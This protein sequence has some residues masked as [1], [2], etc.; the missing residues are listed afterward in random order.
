MFHQLVVHLLDE[1]RTTVA[2]LGQMLDGILD[3]VEAVNLVLHAHIEGRGD[4]AFLLVAVHAQVTVD[5]VVG[6]LMNEGGIAVERKDD[7]LVLCEQGVVVGVGETCLLYT[8]DA[9]DE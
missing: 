2:Q 7:G 9:A 4:G 8:S 3:Q 6:Q 5:T 1:V